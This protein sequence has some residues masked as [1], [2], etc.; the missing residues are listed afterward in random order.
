MVV[1]EKVG[2]MCGSSGEG[3]QNVYQFRR[4]WAKCITVQEK[5]S[6]MYYSSGEGGQ[7]VRWFMSRQKGLT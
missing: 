5:V 2:K 4:R 6:K 3:G 7:N 1:Q